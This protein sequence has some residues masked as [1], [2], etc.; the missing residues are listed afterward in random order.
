VKS[1]GASLNAS[2]D[3]ALHPLYVGIVEVQSGLLQRW[4][5]V[6]VQLESTGQLVKLPLTSVS[7][8]ATPARRSDVNRDM[9]R[10]DGTELFLSCD[11]VASVRLELRDARPPAA[12]AALAAAPGTASAKGVPPL[13][14]ARPSSLRH[15][16]VFPGRVHPLTPRVLTPLQQRL[17]RGSVLSPIPARTD[18]ATEVV[19]RALESGDAARAAEARASPL[20]KS[21]ARKLRRRACFAGVEA[22]RPLVE[23]LAQHHVDDVFDILLEHLDHGANGDVISKDRFVGAFEALVAHHAAAASAAASA[24]KFDAAAC[25]D[26]L[27]ALY[28]QL[29]LDGDGVVD[30]NELVSGLAFVTKGTLEEKAH[31]VF[32]VFD[33]D[34][35]GTMSQGELEQYLVS[36]FTV[37]F[38]TEPTLSERLPHVTPADLAHV[39]VAALYSAESGYDVPFDH[40]GNMSMA[41]FIELEPLLRQPLPSGRGGAS[42]PGLRL[43]RGAEGG[44]ATRSPFG[45]TPGQQ[46]VVISTPRLGA[47]HGELPDTIDRLLNN[48]GTPFAATPIARPSGAVPASA[49]KTAREEEVDPADGG[50]APFSFPTNCTEYPHLKHEIVVELSGGGGGG[51]GRVTR[52]R[53]PSSADALRWIFALRRVGWRCAPGFGVGI[54]VGALPGSGASGDRQD[55]VGL[56]IEEERIIAAYA[57]MELLTCVHDAEL[58]LQTRLVREHAGEVNRL[59]AEHRASVARLAAAHDAARERE[60]HVHNAA[61]HTAIGLRGIAEA[62]VEHLGV[63]YADKL[64]SAAAVMS[65]ARVAETLAAESRA[66]AA[67]V[68][69]ARELAALKQTYAAA[70]AALASDF[71]RTQA[72]L[73]RKVAALEEA[74]R[75]NAATISQFVSRHAETS[76]ALR[77]ERE[78]SAVERS[79]AEEAAAAAAAEHTQVL[80]AVE[81]AY[82]TEAA[83]AAQ[84][85]ERCEAGAA[86]EQVAHAAA[87]KHMQETHRGENYA[88]SAAMAEAMAAATDQ[89]AQVEIERAASAST[90]LEAALRTE[91]QEYAG[92]EAQLQAMADVHARAIA[93]LDV[94]CRDVAAELTGAKDALQFEIEALRRCNDEAAATL[95]AVEKRTAGELSDALQSARSAKDAAASELSAL[96][97]EVGAEEVERAAAAALEAA[98][99][100][101]LANEVAGRAADRDE[102]L[103]TQAQLEALEASVATERA[104]A[105]AVRD[106]VA[107]GAEARNLAAAAMERDLSTEL[108]DAIAASRARVESRDA[109]RA[110]LAEATRAA[111]EEAH[112]GDEVRASQQ[113][114]ARMV[115][116]LR[117]ERDEVSAKASRRE[118]GRRRGR[119]RPCPPLLVSSAST[120]PSLSISLSISL[121]SPHVLCSFSRSRSRV[122]AHP[123]RTAHARV[124]SGAA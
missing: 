12:S 74:Q 3:A 7:T 98:A 62:R 85:W 6:R 122:H 15:S 1:L 111:A 19:M 80:A 63:E 71:E 64:L 45:A 50:G 69:R 118:K 18:A 99:A 22:T 32:T 29:D 31:A 65:D 84:Q 11:E 103:R 115:G 120:H 40:D 37:A 101:T 77:A 2:V 117:D 109:A 82:R 51:R 42:S 113:E 4:H 112:R 34:G 93:A 90:R 73:T 92:A 100:A 106:A 27:G 46:R 75:A 86:E 96:R 23:L 41:T 60:R 16:L 123:P 67:S 30:V 76:V 44:S 53:V 20:S 102:L 110:E 61:L 58:S 38:A 97:A 107:E 35:S 70:L 8:G 87:L 5:R 10:R 104:A 105:A 26:A 119:E 66:E 95:A 25:R 21:A 57:E 114:F 83:Y 108:A 47:M 121:P 88:A 91:A 43:T 56:H 14:A 9:G 78:R 52:L 116:V 124:T 13:S 54:E 48:A 94:Q 36:A 72:A 55:S 17:L 24:E 49:L 79:A 59:V 68:E 39:R 89:A 81:A 28:D 33:V